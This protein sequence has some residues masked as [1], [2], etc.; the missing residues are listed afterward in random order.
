[1][2]QKI[3]I[4]AAVGKNGEIGEE[5]NMPWYLKSELQWFRALTLNGTVIMG[6]TTFKSLENKP[7]ANRLN[8]VVCSRNVKA[9]ESES[10]YF[11]TAASLGQAVAIARTHERRQI[12]LIG[13]AR[14]FEEGM[15]IADEIWLSQINREYP[16]ADTFFPPFGV[17][18]NDGSVSFLY[19]NSGQVWQKEREVYFPKFTAANFV[20]C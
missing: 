16:Q 7:L 14:I 20:R 10:A 8:I 2:K 17:K 9:Q 5:G 6:R 4:V 1:M 12:F 18:E 15:G 11:C 13:G 3:T 19:G